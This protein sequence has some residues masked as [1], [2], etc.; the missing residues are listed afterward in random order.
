MFFFAH[1][2]SGISRHMCRLPTTGPLEHF[3]ILIFF[4]LNPK[5][6]FDIF[7]CNEELKKTLCQNIFNIKGGMTQ[8]NMAG[9]MMGLMTGH[10]MRPRRGSL[11]GAHDGTIEWIISVLERLEKSGTF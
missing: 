3:E 11:I 1:I 6:I 2:E 9:P 8:P 5:I 7:Y 10:R 4:T